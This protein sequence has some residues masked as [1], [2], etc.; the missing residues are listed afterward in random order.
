M[1][2]SKHF[3]DQTTAN[4]RIFAFM[5]AFL[6][7]ALS[8]CLAR[9]Q[10]VEP[11]TSPKG[12]TPKAVVEGSAQMIGPLDS[13]QHLRLAIALRPPH[14]VEEEKFI[15]AL[16]TKGSPSF[17]KF[18]TPEQWNKRFGPSV[19]DEQA[20]VDWA[21]S[22]GFTITNRYPDRLMVDVEAP[23]ATIE[24]ALGLK[25]NQYQVE[26]KMRF[27]NDRDPVL[28]SEMVS[29]IQNVQGL[30]NVNQLK[31]MRKGATTPDFPIYSAGPAV[32]QGASKGIDASAPKPKSLQAD[33]VKPNITGGAYDPTDIYS[34][35]AYDLNALYHLGHCCNPLG[36]S[37]GTPK[38]TSI[39]IATAGAQQGSDF[40]GF[41]NQYPYLAEHWY[42]TNIGGT[43][44]CC[45][46]EGTMD[47]EWSTA[48]SNSFGSY[49]DTATVHMY[50]GINS[51][52]AIFDDIY[53]Q[54]ITDN[55]TRVMSTSWGCEETY[56]YDNTDM[57]TTHA[58]FNTMTGEGWTLVVAAG[59]QGASAG[60]TDRTDVQ[61]PSAD[62]DV[63]S[64]GGATLTLDSNSNFVSDYGWSG[65]PDGCSSNDGGSTGGVS[66]FWPTPGYQSSLGYSHRAV[67]D[68]ALNADWYNTP[69]NLYF[70]GS[71]QGNGGT[72]I[73]APELAGMF[74]NMNAYLLTLGNNCLNEGGPCAP[75]GG[76][77]NPM[78]YYLA[79][80]PS[81]APHYPFY[82][83]TFGCNDNDVTSFYGLTYYCSGTGY[84]LVTG[85]GS[86]NALQL[87]WGF[88]TYRA[89]DFGNPVVTFTGPTTS[90]WY[91]SD[92][93]VSWTVK[94]TSGL[95][96][97]APNG[98]SGF[99]QGWDSIPSDPHSEATPGAGNSF[100][101]G[102]EY[103]NATAGCLDLTGASCSGSVGQGWHYAHVQ[104]WD[105]S[106]FSSGDVTYGPIGYDTVSPVTSATLS[107]TI[108][109]SFYESAVKVTLSAT[110][111]NSGVAST[112][113]QV[114]GLTLYTYT[115]PFTITAPGGHTVTFY[116]VDNAG[117]T[118]ATKSIK[119]ILVTP[120]TT[121]LTS[122]IN[123]STYGQGVTLTAKVTPTVG[124][125]PVGTVTF[126]YGTVTINTATVNSSGVAS[127]IT[128]GF[129][130]GTHAVF[131]VYNPSSGNYLTSTSAIVNQT[132]KASSTKTTLTSSLNPSKLGQGVTFT[133]TVTATT[134][135]VPT[136]TVTF[137][138][139]TSQINVAT[140]NSSGVAS[141]ITASL[142]LGTHSITAVYNGSTDDLTSTSSALT[143]TVTAA[144]TTTTLTSSL[145]PSTLGA[146]VTFTAKVTPGS[147]AAAT[148]TVS[149]YNGTTLIANGTLN[150]SDVATITTSGLTVGT[151]SI[152]AVYNGNA[153]DLASKSA[154]LS[155]VVNQ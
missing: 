155:Q 78:V 122:S 63:V 19:A 59:D 7:S 96:D 105:N 82:D 18:L 11:F 153:L 10:Q 123:P 45:D 53:H 113:Y 97:Y 16:R 48:M 55:S 118:E 88:N 124:G 1:P 76:L 109:G 36:N 21:I 107:G 119:F 62:P 60:C 87:A 137:Y 85:W 2:Y 131:A 69:Q 144:T 154:T 110:D 143:Q 108:V 149:F 115:G 42:T 31:P 30:N 145:N 13:A 46:G 67:P 116:S 68:L 43:P 95:T 103:A 92:Q 52:F 112:K 139:G 39:A 104:A 5:L 54:I 50:D 117:N 38:E 29:I 58:I 128:G 91:N 51:S 114:D 61:Y 8:P 146:A 73:V 126:K 22:Q 102:P 83:I 32:S 26:G 136:G 94:D 135:S 44:T 47:F 56:C 35:E 79:E 130:V 90:K 64:A 33:G 57:N 132:V 77:V 133:A 75:M 65:G 125:E 134:G 101:S 20:V 28:P 72:S 37:G 142:A 129:S 98:V 120:T 151:H 141:I 25:L 34:S 148:G 23:V 24:K 3:K 6:L 15:E 89:G 111:A 84:D 66:T 127:I 17:G 147:G 12:I 93:V 14:P 150:S 99:T 140:L 100:Y 41:H 4:A 70:E 40:I 106:G 27:S 81:Y 9:A 71:L 152:L 121:S 138:N 74:A 80:N 86:F 49:A